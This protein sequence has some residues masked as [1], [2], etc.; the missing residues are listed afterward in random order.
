VARAFVRVISNPQV[1]R[2]CVGG[3]LRS[4][5]LMGQ[6][7]RI[8]ANLMRPDTTGA[9]EIGYRAMEAVAQLL[10]DGVPEPG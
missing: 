3:G 7:M 6:L 8:M 5:P 4:A 1:M 10:R 9:A 2:A